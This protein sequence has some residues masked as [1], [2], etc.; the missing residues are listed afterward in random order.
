M[1]DLFFFRGGV[2]ADRRRYRS[3][4]R[5]NNL[6]AEA[7]GAPPKPGTTTC[8][9]AGTPLIGEAA[10]ISRSK[11]RKLL[12]HLV[13]FEEEA[14]KDQ[15]CPPVLCATACVC[16]RAF[17]CVWNKRERRERERKR[18]RDTRVKQIGRPAE[19]RQPL[20]D[21]FWRHKLPTAKAALKKKNRNKTYFATALPSNLYFTALLILLLGVDK[22]LQWTSLVAEGRIS[23][24]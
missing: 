10:A 13:S 4:R 11:E 21:S 18:E 8:R 24:L 14:A 9:C 19:R 12:F 1:A 15:G 23:G 20:L 2:E 16:V 7:S 17:V 22:R 5:A 6:R 3:A